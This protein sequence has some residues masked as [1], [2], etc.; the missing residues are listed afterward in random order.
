MTH[1]ASR[2]RTL[3]LL[4]VVIAVN[5]VVACSDNSPI[6][7]IAGPDAPVSS[8]FTSAV[9][10][11]GAPPS[12]SER[13]ASE[14]I[15]RGLALALSDPK[16]RQEI[17]AALATSGIREGKLHFGSFMAGR[18]ARIL[19]AMTARAAMDPTQFRALFSQ[20]RGFELYMP[21]AA[22]R[23]AWKGGDDVLV[24][25][26]LRQAE[27]PVA[28]DVRGTR[29]VL[30]R[31]TPPSQP[32]LMLDQIET[33]F[34]QQV[35]ANLGGRA[36]ISCAVSPGSIAAASVTDAAKQCSGRTTGGALTLKKSFVSNT[37]GPGNFSDLLPCDGRAR[38]VVHG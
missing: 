20:V 3:W 33:D 16:M 13:Q 1:P 36:L 34:G 6:D 11:N 9:V 4:A 8:A 15:A 31:K 23:D 21:V 25:V 2:F 18:G 37:V 28:F 7:R 29:Q 14:A 19:S 22:Q 32:V 26:A 10:P 5:S 12:V 24:G 30:D 38:T 27:T 17:K 35:A